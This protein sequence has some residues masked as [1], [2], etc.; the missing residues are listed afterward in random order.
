MVATLPR[1]PGAPKPVANTSK[2]LVGAPTADDRDRSEPP[3]SFK[4]MTPT[5]PKLRNPFTR[6]VLKAGL[7]SCLSAVGAEMSRG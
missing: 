3:R 2:K 4:A 7:A 1:L 5:D 6:D